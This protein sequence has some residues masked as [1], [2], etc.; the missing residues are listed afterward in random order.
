M[1]KA[2]LFAVLSV[3]A[4]AGALVAVDAGHEWAKLAVPATFLFGLL[5]LWM[6]DRGFNS[7]VVASM[8]LVGVF[9]LMFFH[10][11]WP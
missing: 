10:A 6:K 5:S 3:A 2:M 11:F 1:T 4:F 9:S 7:N 8:M